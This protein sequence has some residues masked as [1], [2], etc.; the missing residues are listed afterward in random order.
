M[1]EYR[2]ISTNA[3]CY[4]DVAQPG[5]RTLCVTVP[6]MVQC[7]VSENTVF[8]GIRRQ[9]SD[10]ANCWPHHKEGNAIYLHYTGLRQNYQAMVRQTLMEGLDTEEWY[11]RNARMQEILER[12][13]PYAR[14]SAKDEAELEVAVYP[15]GEKLSPA[16]REKASEACRWLSVL[17]H[18]GT[19]QKAK[20]LGYKTLSELYGDIVFVVNRLKVGLPATYV[21][22]R[23]KV[24]EYGE[25]GIACCIDMRGQDNKN[26]AKVSSEEQVAVLQYICSRG[27][28]YNAQQITQLYNLAA[29]AKGWAT[30]GRRSALNYLKEYALVVEAGRNGSEAFRNKMAMQRRRKRPAEALSFWSVDGWTVELYYQREVRGSDGKVVRTYTNRLTAVVVIDASC[31]FPVGYAVGDCESVKLITAALKNAIDYVR[32]TLGGNYRPYQIQSDHYGIKS[33]GNI[34]SNVAEHFTPARVKNAK[35]KPVEPYFRYLNDSYCQFYF[36]NANWSG[37]GV[38]SI[39]RNQPNIDLLNYRKRSFPDREG[40]I[41]QIGWIIQQDREKKMAEWVRAWQRMPETD[42]LALSREDYLL[43]FGQRTDRIIRMHS[44]CLEPVLLGQK[45][46]YDTFDPEFRKDPLQSWTVMYDER[47]LSTIL[48]ADES[49]KRRHLLNAVHE[50]PMAL[51]DRRPGDYEAHRKVDEYNK[52][53]LEPAVVGQVKWAEEQVE[54]IFMQ[55]PELEAFRAANLLPDSNGQHKAYLQH[56]AVIKSEEDL[57]AEMDDKLGLNRTKAADRQRE[58]ELKASRKQAEKAYEEYALSK[59]D[60]SKFENI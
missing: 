25:K 8:D 47:D 52:N 5:E 4:S 54:R 41:R 59:I 20:E 2:I 36:G 32:D 12:L 30:I 56:S 39:Q 37:H 48:V 17:V 10:K 42:R 23:R 40:C 24:C 9:R 29:K 14:L 34:Y 35:A 3:A 16:A 18:V 28:S 55:T 7:G 43:S 51:R 11:N 15:T 60:L 58:K 57:V 22:L 6:E 45:R 50:Q 33:M 26:A 31:N 19:K 1:P 21:R 44:G 38:K 46:A 53:V 13:R 27:A 49:M